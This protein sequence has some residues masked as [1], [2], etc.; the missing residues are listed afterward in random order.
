[1]RS[2]NV[3]KSARQA[4]NLPTKE[5]ERG[6]GREKREWRVARRWSARVGA[7]EGR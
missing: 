3:Q 7:E 5:K 4:N 2:F 6:R 1:M